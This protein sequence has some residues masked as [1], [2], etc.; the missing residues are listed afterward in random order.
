MSGTIG[1]SFRLPLVALTPEWVQKFAL[2][3]SRP[4]LFT[5]DQL[6][7]GGKSAPLATA[8]AAL[9]IA[10][11]RRICVV[12]TGRT[13]SCRLKL[14]VHTL[15]GEDTSIGIW[16][17]HTGAWMR[18]LDE[19]LAHFVACMKPY[20]G[21]SIPIETWR[22]L[23]T[24]EGPAPRDAPLG[25]AGEFPVLFQR[26]SGDPVECPDTPGWRNYWSPSTARLLDFPRASG[27]ERW[28]RFAQRTPDGGW[29][30]DITERPTDLGS[31][32]G[33]GALVAFSMRFPQIGFRRPPRRI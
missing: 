21:Y 10:V 6:F 13:P 1:H 20:Y 8:T 12:G 9:M 15:S 14:S 7:I 31:P 30:V 2:A 24:R 22:L 3:V 33:I 23:E 19:F 18:E 29:F 5:V 17:P 16:H 28:L 11:S 25:A 26:T 4:G 27:D 32:D